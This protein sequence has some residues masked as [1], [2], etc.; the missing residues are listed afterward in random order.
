MS[1]LLRNIFEKIVKFNPKSIFLYPHGP[2]YINR[3]LESYGDTS[4][5]IVNNSKNFEFWYSFND[6][7]PWM[8]KQLNLKKH[9][10]NCVSY[11]FFK[12]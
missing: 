6:E 12:T 9:K 10:C 2:H 11:P 8:N 1:T 7:K 3:T 4:K 5:I